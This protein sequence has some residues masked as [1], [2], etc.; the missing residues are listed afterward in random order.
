MSVQ[1]LN[2]KKRINK[3]ETKNSIPYHQRMTIILSIHNDNLFI[4]PSGSWTTTTTTKIQ[5]DDFVIITF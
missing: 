3:R 4:H 1:L 5:F 2:Y